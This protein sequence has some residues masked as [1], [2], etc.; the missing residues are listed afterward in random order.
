MDDV[1]GSPGSRVVSTLVLG[2]FG[3]M[4][5]SEALQHLVTDG[6]PRMIGPAWPRSP[7]VS[8][9]S[10]GRATCGGAAARRLAVASIRSARPEAGVALV[11]AV[12]VAYPIVDAYIG[13]N[14]AR[15]TTPAA[16]LGVAHETVAFATT[17]GHRLTGWYVPSTNRAAVILYPGVGAT[18]RHA[19]MLIDHG[20]GVLLVDHRGYGDS[21]GEPNSWGWGG[22]HDIHGAVAFLQQRSDVDPDRIGALGLSVGGEVLLHAA[23]DNDG[24]RAVVSEG[25]GARSWSEYRHIDGP[26]RWLWA[27]STI[28]RMIATSVFA[29]RMPP[30]GLHDLVPASRRRCC[31]STRPADRR[32]S[33]DRGLLRTGRRTEAAVAN[34]QRPHR[35]SRGR[36][37]AVRAPCRRLPRRRAPAGTRV[38]DGASARPLS[39]AHRAERIVM[40]LADAEGARA[41]NVDTM[42]VAC[43][44]V[45]LAWLLLTEWVP[46]APLND[47]AASTPGDRLRVGVVNYGV[48]L[49]IAGGVADGHGGGCD[50]RPGARGRSGSSGTWCRGG[51]RTSG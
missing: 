2:L 38:R 36:S 1:A 20:Y 40:L 37:G 27:P 39:V 41:V 14:M 18:Q 8:C 11:V 3:V 30:P 43:C 32:R 12:Y 4:L 49:V 10:S 34:R 7:V 19:R 24:L 29:N 42:A 22:E 51:C 16:D 15:R 21:G 45:M 26:G 6:R 35:R 48:L 28:N 47:L 13:S 33:A 17:D 25:A 9:S 50:R 44:L 31:S 23:A 46:L 5:G